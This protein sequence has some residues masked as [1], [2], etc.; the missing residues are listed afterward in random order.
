MPSKWILLLTAVV[1]K[2]LKT[3][4]FERNVYK[5]RNIQKEYCA[6]FIF[7]AALNFDF[8]S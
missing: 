8:A 6:I 2:S 3:V 7:Y 4:R 1:F 5:R